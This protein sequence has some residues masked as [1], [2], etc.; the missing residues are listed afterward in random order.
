MSRPLRI[1]FP[2][3]VYYVTSRGDRLEPIYR[4]DADRL[5]QLDVLA[6]ALARFDADVLAYCLMG[7]HYHLGVQ[8]HAGQLSRLIPQRR[9]HPSLQPAPWPRRA[10]VPRAL[11]GGAGR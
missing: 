3:A 10:S 2:G 1:E 6:D 11:Q 7:N 4:D 9:L 8:T 5:C